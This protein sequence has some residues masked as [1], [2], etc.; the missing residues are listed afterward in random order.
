MRYCKIALTNSSQIFSDRQASLESGL[1]SYAIPEEIHEEIAVGS[2][3]LVPFRNQKENGLVIDI[4][5]SSPEEHKFKVRNILETIFPK[6]FIAEELV[7]LIKFTAE[8]YACAYSE[9]I[10]AVFPKTILKKPEKIVSL[11][12]PECQEDNPVINALKKARKN[13]AKWQR[14]KTL[15]GLGEKD[16]KKEITKLKNKQFVQVE[17]QKAELKTN[18]I[19]NPLDKL[20]SD[21]EQKEFKYTDEQQAVI[22]TMNGFSGSNKFLL[23][24]VT[25][26]GKT[27][28]Y[29]N[30]I[31]KTL[32]QGKSTIFLVP[33]ISLAPQ[34]SERLAQHFGKD[35]IYVWHSALSISEKKN[36]FEALLN[37]EA[38]II[39]GA[40]SAIFTPVKNIGLIVLDEEHEN[41]YKQEEPNPR[42]H[43]HK[44]AIKRSELN[45]CPI[46]FGS[47]TPSVDL[48]Y[49]ASN[50]EYPDYHLLE[51]KKR[52]FDNPLPEVKIIDMRKE[53]NNGNKTV[54][55]RE[56]R[57]A[58]TEAL[59]Q[60]EQ[61]ILFLNK[62]GT[63]SHVFCRNC[64]YVYNCSNCD[65]KTV[66]HQDKQKLICHYCSYEE[67]HPVDCPECGAATIKFFGLGTQKLEEE[68]KKAFP[69]ARVARLDSDNARQDNNYLKVWQ[70]FKNQDIDMVIGTQMIAKGLDLDNL[71]TVGVISADANLSQLDY[72]ADER[73]FQLMTQVAGRAGR[74]QKQGKVFFQS[75]QPENETLI[76]SKSHDYKAFYEKEIALRKFLAYPPFATIL[77]FRAVNEKESAAIDAANS[78]HK[79]VYAV[80]E[81]NKIDQDQ[82]S[83]MGPC[84]SLIARMNNK[85]RYHVVIKVKSSTKSYELLRALK[86]SFLSMPIQ[87][88]TTTIDVDNISLY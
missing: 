85:F 63:A 29:I 32:D 50:E 19:S 14:L 51:L 38:K 2:M 65:S 23:H 16:L 5:E 76:F 15:A 72:K 54:F 56:L 7:E 46:I 40:R 88:A 20:D 13:Q 47:A 84:P 81:N 42:Y 55:A 9:V 41:S 10:N 80:L 26:S 74:R 11:I 25:G 49:K 82:I 45:N 86:S 73:S 28:V 27:E 75:Y 69:E 44:V 53:F 64:G 71:N 66:Y 52:V 4:Y 61:V 79:N 8:Y 59:E 1:L 31:Q 21:Q 12:N 18:K 6:G 62:R 77:R 37:D 70:D 34:L 60:K 33:E 39:V 68:T 22:E 30:Q 3:V 17:F 58:I 36:T 67:P 48:Y 24:G 87:T 35:N 43:T 78:I 57:E 83:I